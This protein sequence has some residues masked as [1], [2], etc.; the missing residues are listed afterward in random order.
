M[1]EGKKKTAISFFSKTLMFSISGIVL[2]CMIMSV[3]SYAIMS[4]A[5]TGSLEE[6]AT[7][8]ATLWKNRFEVEDLKRGKTSLSSDS[9]IQKKLVSLLDELSNGNANVAQGFIFEPDLVDGTKTRIISNPTHLLKVGLKPGELFDQPTDMVKA[10]QS[11]KQT[12]S[13]VIP[14][15][16]NDDIG[17]WLTVLVP[18]LDQ[19]Q[20][21]VA[22]FG[23]D[24]NASII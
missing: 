20:Q 1:G 6:Q 10:F 18:V 17:S 13:I 16:Y 8:V 9:T 21:L 3:I 22:V 19:Q 5:L 2:A 23:I 12:K 11:L 14:P 4:R 15:I 24:V 7:G